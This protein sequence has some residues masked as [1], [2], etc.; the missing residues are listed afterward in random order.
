MYVNSWEFNYKFY[1]LRIYE[2]FSQMIAKPIL[3]P[4]NLLG[5]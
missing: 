1:F 2:S 4:E 5:R 3:K